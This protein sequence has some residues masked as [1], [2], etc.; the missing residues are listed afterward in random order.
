MK[1]AIITG[2]SAGMGEL[3]AK[4]LSDV[5]PDIECVW[6]IAR[7][8][9]RLDEIGKGLKIKAVSIPLDLT[10]SE[11]IA[12]LAKKLQDEKPDVKLLVNNAGC[13]YLG[14]IGETDSALLERMVDLDV[15]ALTL[16]TNEVVPFMSKGS[17]IINISSIASF[18]PNPRMTVYSSSKAYV[19]SFS[20]GLRDELRNKGISVLAVC[21]GPMDT[22]FIEIGGIKGHSQMFNTLPYCTPEKVVAG[23]LKAAKAGRAFYTPRAFFK[24][25]RF[26][27]HILPRTITV[28]FART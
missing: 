4:K 3:F 11:D 10:K 14:N 19:S 22:E 18:C 17:N 24:L 6:L 25:Y 13:G 8:V 20:I 5:F 9:E 21:P 15:K 12:S 1:T 7:R 16:V 27:A 28:K 2:A 26:L 23:S